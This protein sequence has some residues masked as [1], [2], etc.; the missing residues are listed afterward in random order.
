M[1]NNQK[2]LVFPISMIMLIFTMAL[3]SEAKQKSEPDQLVSCVDNSA[4]YLVQ[5]KKYGK[6]FPDEQT[7]YSYGYTFDQVQT[8]DCSSELPFQLM[9]TVDNQFGTGF[10]LMKKVN[11]PSVFAC[12]LKQSYYLC[13]KVSNAEQATEQ[14]GS[15]WPKQIYNTQASSM[16]MLVWH[17]LKSK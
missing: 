11:D 2:I 12:E 16:D 13:E 14:Y 4:V 10:R 17:W 5:N 15:N 7:F 6:V 1:K 9:G 3:P 8:I